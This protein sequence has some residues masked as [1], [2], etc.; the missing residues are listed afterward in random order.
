M[1]S[2]VVPSA[3]ATA[4][5]RSAPTSLFAAAA[6]SRPRRSRLSLNTTLMGSNRRCCCFALDPGLHVVATLSRSLPG[7]RRA[8]DR[9]EQPDL[10]GQPLASGAV[11]EVS[12]DPSGASDSSGAGN[13]AGVAAGAVTAGRLATD[14]AVSS[15]SPPHADAAVRQTTAHIAMPRRRVRVRMWSWVLL[16]HGIRSRRR[17]P[18]G[19]TSADGYIWRTLEMYGEAEHPPSTSKPRHPSRRRRRRRRGTPPPWRCSRLPQPRH[20]RVALHAIHHRAVD[21]ALATLGAD[22]AGVDDVAADA[23]LAVDRG[24]VAVRA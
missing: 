3:R 12:S 10:D 17:K 5:T 13:S 21:V 18:E 8:G 6:Q 1:V 22:Q 7:G 19:S 4:M 2:S 11:D 23:L 24:D 9:P 15:S 16:G 20:E 14:G